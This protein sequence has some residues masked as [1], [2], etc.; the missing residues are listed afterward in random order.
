[1]RIVAGRFRRRQLL[2]NPGQTTRPITDRAKVI[3]FDRIE[4]KCV[5]ARV[6]DIF[7]GT[8]SLGFEA[9]SRGAKTAV[10]AEADHRAHSLLKQNAAQLGIEQ[11]VVC[12]RVDV[13]RCRPCT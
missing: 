1:M 4:A 11:D 5:G 9:L 7:A 13:T 10:F 12:W 2:V 3:L 6:A 8:G